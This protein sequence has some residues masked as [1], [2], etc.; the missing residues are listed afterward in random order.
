MTPSRNPVLA[1]ACLLG[2]LLL[3]FLASCDSTPDKREGTGDW[4]AIGDRVQVTDPNH[5]DAIAADVYVDIDGTVDLPEIGTVQVAGHTANEIRELLLA[6]YG[7]YHDDLDIHVEITTG[8]RNY[9]VFGEVARQGPKP[10]TSD[11]TVFEAVRDASPNPNSANLGRVK[12][13]R[14]DPREPRIWTIDVSENI[15]TG[16]SAFDALI[17]KRDIIYVPAIEES[18]PEPTPAPEI[19]PDELQPN[20]WW[21]YGGRA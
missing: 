6:R 16:N 9:F 12:L 5:A 2:A 21:A 8:G 20:L 3:T 7:P 15:D 11:I 10:L 18:E 13:I 4:V 17:R 1:A 19:V 14:A